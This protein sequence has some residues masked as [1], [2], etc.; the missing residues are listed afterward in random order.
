MY[1]KN[2]RPYVVRKAPNRVFHRLTSFLF[3]LLFC[4]FFPNLIPYVAQTTGNFPEIF[5]SY[6]FNSHL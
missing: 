6:N 4:E 2:D 3:G 5:T 1:T